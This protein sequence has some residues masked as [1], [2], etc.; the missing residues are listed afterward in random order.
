MS[1]VTLGAGF[2]RGVHLPVNSVPTRAGRLRHALGSDDLHVWVLVVVRTSS[3]YSVRLVGL[4][5]LW[6]L[7]SLVFLLGHFLFTP[8][9][10]T[11]IT[12][13]NR[14]VSTRAILTRVSNKIPRRLLIGRITC[15]KTPDITISSMAR[16]QHLI[17]AGREILL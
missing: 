16:S 15:D 10:S 3:D 9:K 2:G 1:L 7:G 6:Y 5:L 17:L 8:P 4:R 11:P 14:F 12:R 13:L